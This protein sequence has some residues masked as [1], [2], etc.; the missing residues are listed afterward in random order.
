MKKQYIDLYAI[1]RVAIVAIAIL[2]VIAALLILGGWLCWGD[3]CLIQTG[4]KVREFSWSDR[5]VNVRD[6]AFVMKFSRPMSR[7]SVANNLK[8]TIP[9][10]PD[11]EDPLPGKMSWA[12]KSRV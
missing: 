3:K 1:D 7:E 12:G 6:T 4:P 11:I 2:T 8:I 5:I 10:R 9:E